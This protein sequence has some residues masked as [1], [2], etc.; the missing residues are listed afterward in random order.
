MSPIVDIAGT[1][2]I[3]WIQLHCTRIREVKRAARSANKTNL[4]DHQQL[5][6]MTPE[7]F[8]K[9]AALISGLFSQLLGYLCC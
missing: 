2:E 1:I 9:T 3:L 5:W 6:A 8:L 7:R 4:K